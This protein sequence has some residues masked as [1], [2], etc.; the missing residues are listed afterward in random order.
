MDAVAV[1]K[2]TLRTQAR[3]NHGH[4]YVVELWLKNTPSRGKKWVLQIRNTPGSWYMSTLLEG[5]YNE[6]NSKIWIDF[7]QN[8]LCS[9]FGEVM[10]EAKEQV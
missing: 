5:N 9:N 6:K 8:W 10:A 7:G 3:D 2:K 4:T 1:E